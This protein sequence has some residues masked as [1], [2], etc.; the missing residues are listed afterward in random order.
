MSDI[1]SP[2]DLE[3]LTGK[4]LASA[5]IRWLDRNGWAYV[6]SGAGRP[7]VLRE[8]RNQRLGV[9]EKLTITASQPNWL[10][11]A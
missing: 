2:Q 7:V 11:L 3:A 9:G 10:K 4:K 5:Q 1:L 8:Y 6:V